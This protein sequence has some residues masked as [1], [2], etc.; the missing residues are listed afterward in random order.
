MSPDSPGLRWSVWLMQLWLAGGFGA[1]FTRASF[2]NCL[3]L[4]Q[5]IPERRFWTVPFWR[6]FGSVE[7]VW[8]GRN[9]RACPLEGRGRT[10]ASR[11]PGL[12]DGPGDRRDDDPEGDWNVLVEMNEFHV[13]RCRAAARPPLPKRKQKR[14]GNTPRQSRMPRLAQ[15]QA[16]RALERTVLR[17]A[18]SRA[19]W[20]GGRIGTANRAEECD[21][22]IPFTGCT[23]SPAG[24]EPNPSGSRRSWLEGV[25]T[26]P[27]IQILSGGRSL[28][29]PVV[30]ACNNRLASAAGKHDD[31][32]V[33]HATTANGN[34]DV[35][36]APALLAGPGA[37]E[38]A[39]SQ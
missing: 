12:D 19:T 9:M 36:L 10:V 37:K 21:D 31:S 20:P 23:P 1:G 25:R 22:T 11:R 5:F 16:A 28:G 33:H 17:R 26:T 29:R 14:S 35:P 18:R 39:V 38:E 2:W 6:N 32:A 7:S 34:R 15:G 30:V 27:E 24:S 8:A 3:I 4:S 13:L